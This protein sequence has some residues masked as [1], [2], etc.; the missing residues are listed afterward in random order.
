MQ[1]TTLCLPKSK[2]TFKMKLRCSF[3]SRSVISFSD[4]RSVTP[5]SLYH[6]S[7]SQRLVCKLFP[8][9]Y[10]IAPVS[11]SG[12][13]STNYFMHL[14]LTVMPRVFSFCTLYLFFLLPDMTCPFLSWKDSC[15]SF[16]KH[17][18]QYLLWNLPDLC[19]G[20]HCALEYFE[21]KYPKRC[22]VIFYLYVC[23]L[24]LM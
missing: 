13:I 2:L 24:Y 23:L 17:F 7:V 9:A 11:L 3:F 15:I 22:V 10:N 16:K 1:Y 14:F 19:Q 4:Y 20:K 18:Q 5:K 12:L 8:L 21:S 6:F